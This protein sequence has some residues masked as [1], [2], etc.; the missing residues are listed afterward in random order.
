MSKDLQIE[1]RLCALDVLLRA[2]PWAV[3]PSATQFRGLFH[4]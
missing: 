2:E 4:D 1:L 3:G